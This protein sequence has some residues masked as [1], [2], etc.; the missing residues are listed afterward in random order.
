MGVDGVGFDLL[1]G[2][3]TADKVGN[4]Y[5]TNDPT[6]LPTCPPHSM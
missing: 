2:K 6:R 4:Q 3:M 5:F 1:D